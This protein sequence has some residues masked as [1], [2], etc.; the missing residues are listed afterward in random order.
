ME[1]V[2]SPGCRS[3]AKILQNNNTKILNTGALDSL[4]MLMNTAPGV[5][6]PLSNLIHTRTHWSRQVYQATVIQKEAAEHQSCDIEV[7]LRKFES[8]RKGQ[9]PKYNRTLREQ[10]LELLGIEAVLRFNRV[11]DWKGF[12]I[13]YLVP[14]GSLEELK[15]FNCAVCKE[16]LH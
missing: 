9:N 8:I 14:R 3:V 1:F 13:K 10:K 4:V 16:N 5:V 2:D 12:K 6:P 15:G 7:R 11:E